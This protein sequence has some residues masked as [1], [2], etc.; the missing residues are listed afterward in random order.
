VLELFDRPAFRTR[1]GEAG[2]TLVLEKYDWR[3]VAKTQIAAWEQ[4]IAV[5]REKVKAEGTQGA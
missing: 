4:A 1:L 2:R 5:R 3:K